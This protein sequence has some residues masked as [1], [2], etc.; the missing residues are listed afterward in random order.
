MPVQSHMTWTSLQRVRATLNH[1]EPDRVP[2]DLGGSVVTGIHLRAYRLLRQFL[3]LPA[4]ELQ[5]EDLRQQLALVHEDTKKRL[6]VDVY[7]LSP[8]RAKNFTF[9]LWSE[10]GYDKLRD[11]WGIEWWRPQPDGLY[12]DMRAHPLAKVDTLAGLAQCQFPDPWDPGRFEGM[13]ARAHQLFCQAQVAYLLGRN[14]PGI[15]EL[16]LWLRGFENF[17]C[18]LL[19]NPSFA[20]ALLDRLLEIKMR[21]WE[22]A[23][24]CVGPHVL[25][26]AEADDLGSQDRLLVR[27]ELYRKFLKPRH[28]RLFGFIRKQAAVPVKVFFHSCGAIAPIIPDLIE[29][30][31][32]V[33]NPIQ[34]SAK[35]MDT[36]ALKAQF[37]ADLTFY[38]GGIDTQTILPHGTPG[39][40]RDEVRRRIHDLAP[41]GGFIFN[42]VHNIQADVPPRNIV[43]M[44]E[45]LQEFGL[46]QS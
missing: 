24:A 42:P 46:Y 28:T 12:Y 5:P 2:Y 20:E 38:G 19:S 7:G 15:F 17:Y 14:A 26:V 21:Y 29:S 30:G 32:D 45:A 22:R 13:A 27:A 3:N 9:P 39:Q 35:G 25:L 44:W 33:L 37:G 18:D 36:R 43:A 34:V 6:N 41:G 40:V 4:V 11:E 10:N 1:T 16:A 23:L 31:V 8:G